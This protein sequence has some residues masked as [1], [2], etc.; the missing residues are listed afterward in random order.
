MND[1]SA[2]GRIFFSSTGRSLVDEDEIVVLS[3]GVDIGS[4]TSHLVFSRIVLERLDSRYVVTT[5]ET[6]YQSDI[7]LTPYAAEE[8]ID[9]ASLG[10][11]I[12]RQYKDAKVD[13]DEIDTG[14]LILTGVAVRRSNARKIGEL[15]ARQAG[16]M[17]AVSAGDNLE[18]VMAAYGSGAVARSIRDK[19][20]VMNV[21]VGGGT[22]KISICQDGK[23][24]DLTAVDVG[25][26]LVCI[27]SSG[28]ITR[29]EEAGRRF[30]SELGLKLEL[31]GALAPEAARALTTRM[32]DRLFEAMAGASPTAAS[33][34]LLR[35]DPIAYRGKVDQITFS[36]GVS[37]YVY[38]REAETF[39][40]LGA[41]LAQEISARLPGSGMEL[42]PSTE[43]IRATVVGASQYTTQVSG[44]TI[45]VAPM[46]TLP[47][48]NVPVI[49]PTFPLDAET[50]EPA[51]VAS[52][53]KGVLKRLD[54]GAG[55][56]PV[57]IFVPWRG[58]ATF[59]RLHD[60][61]QGAVEGL[62]DIL[63]KGHPLVLAG[64]GDVGGLIGIH[65]HEE[66]RIDNAVVSIDGLEL[67]DFDY[68]DI[69]TMLP[70]SGAVP[71]VIKSL[72]FPTSA[73]LGKDWQAAPRAVGEPATAS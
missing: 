73:A 7:L 30:A 49:A 41:L 62:A 43:G 71:V 3:V 64:D 68:I 54:L 38:G 37:E 44:S 42:V 47:L 36:G 65:L 60:F 19:T 17:V 29:I 66:M 14:A 55:N 46:E 32:T 28:R 20:T 57:A 51:V 67:K 4:S 15:F 70:S 72:I 35:L 34:G 12:E 48:R 56:T 23:V 61:C 22:S 52:A 50:I 53:I 58:S 63:A 39:G 40:D 25:A 21:D 16:K 10:A 2:G 69:G 11:F 59:Q 1:E 27:D 24:V 31:G 6:F 8:T 33:A 5:R 18:T 9:A 13:P 26:R 45:Y